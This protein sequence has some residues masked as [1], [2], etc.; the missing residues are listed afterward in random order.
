MLDPE[1]VVYDEPTSGLDPITSRM[2]DD[3]IIQT[4]QRFGVTSVV[5]THDMASALHIAHRIHLLAAGTIV[6]DG[7]PAEF[8]NTRHELGR[9]FLDSSG[10]ALDRLLHRQ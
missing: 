8:A 9:R 7:T 4:S 1:I 6:M 5:I 3:L 2:V 10:V